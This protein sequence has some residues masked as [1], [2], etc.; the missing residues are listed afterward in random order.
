[1]EWGPVELGMKNGTRDA[2]HNQADIKGSE[3]RRNEAWGAWG[4][5]EVCGAGRADG[6]GAGCVGGEGRASGRPCTGGRSSLG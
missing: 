3:A 4:R 1:M 5:G 6:R 2:L